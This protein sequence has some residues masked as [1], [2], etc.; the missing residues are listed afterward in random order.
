MG[1]EIRI[2]NKIDKKGNDSIVSLLFE[3]IIL[4]SIVWVALF[5]GPSILLSRIS[6]LRHDDSY[7]N[8]I[9]DLYNNPEKYY[10]YLTLGSIFCGVVYFTFQLKYKNIVDIVIDGNQIKFV[11]SNR[12]G[13]KFKRKSYNSNDIQP[14]IKKTKFGEYQ[15][16][17]FYHIGRSIGYFEFRNITG[18]SDKEKELIEKITLLNKC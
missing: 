14:E 9:L 5:I 4:V 11:I 17:K 6:S 2:S 10:L 13:Y 16:I 15:S 1:E 18:L 12:L 3:V 7:I 8:F